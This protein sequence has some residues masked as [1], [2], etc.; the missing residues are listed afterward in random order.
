V[1]VSTIGQNFDPDAV[2]QG[3]EVVNHE[4]QSSFITTAFLS[5]TSSF[6]SGLKEMIL[7]C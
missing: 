5:E 2:A 1:F 6:S 7:A 3:L 4:R